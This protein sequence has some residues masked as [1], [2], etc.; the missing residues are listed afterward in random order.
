MTWILIAY[1][2]SLNDHS[3]FPLISI[4]RVI[5]VIWKASNRKQNLQLARFWGTKEST[6]TSLPSKR[7]SGFTEHKSIWFIFSFKQMKVVTK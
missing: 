5:I 4:L 2:V 1:I 3:H 7:S 6:T